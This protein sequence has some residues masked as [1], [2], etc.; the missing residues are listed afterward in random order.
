MSRS[1]ENLEQ[2]AID[3]ILE[4]RDGVRAGLL[5]AYSI[6]FPLFTSGSFSFVCISI[7]NAYCGSAHSVASSSASE[8]SPSE[9]PGRLRSWKNLRAPCRQAVARSLFSAADIKASRTEQTELVAEIA[10]RQA[11]TLRG[12]SPMANHSCSILSRPVTSPTCWRTISRT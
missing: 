10:R 7:A 11:K 4:R 9:E 8:T 12:S 6:A 3:V 1:L 2:F 5:R